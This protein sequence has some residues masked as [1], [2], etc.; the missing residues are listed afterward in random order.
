MLII[1]FFFL[2]SGIALGAEPVKIGVVY[3]LTGPI[4]AAGSYQRAGVE[5]ARDKINAE[6]GIIGRPIPAFCR[7]W[8]Q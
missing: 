7:R 6:G 4:A 8:R 3:P 2:F 5:I 1:S